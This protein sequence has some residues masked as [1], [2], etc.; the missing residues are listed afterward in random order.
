MKKRMPYPLYLAIFLM[1]LG[2]ICSLLLSVI[3]YITSPI[4]EKNNQKALSETFEFFGISNTIDATDD[5]ELVDGVN[6]VYQGDL[7]DEKVYIFDVSVKNQFLKIGMLIVVNNDGVIKNVKNMTTLTTNSKDNLFSS[8]FGVIYS[9]VYNYEDNLS[10]VTGATVTSTSIKQAL[11]IA[12]SQFD[13]V[14]EG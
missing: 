1:V 8:D 5:Y 9:T 6:K 14:K 4:I 10:I 3:N 11:S 2:V 13:V 12:K 7:A